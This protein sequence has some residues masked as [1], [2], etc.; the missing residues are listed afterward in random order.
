[1]N[2]Y[3]ILFIYININIYIYIYIYYKADL[4]NL[5]LDKLTQHLFHVLIYS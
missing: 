3:F 5:L 4:F 2:L 1:M